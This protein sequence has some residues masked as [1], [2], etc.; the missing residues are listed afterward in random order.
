MKFDYAR[1]FFFSFLFVLYK[2]VCL[3]LEVLASPFLSLFKGLSPFSYQSL[4]IIMSLFQHTHTH[5]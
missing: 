4:Y 1:C 5:T 3:F 2:F